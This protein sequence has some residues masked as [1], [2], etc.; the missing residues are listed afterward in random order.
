MTSAK[1][2]LATQA[3][4]V[5]EYRINHL[6]EKLNDRVGEFITVEIQTETI[7]RIVCNNQKK[8]DNKDYII[9]KSWENNDS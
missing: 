1:N 7:L 9:F 8:Y 3:Q 6:G 2:E 5:P 4:N